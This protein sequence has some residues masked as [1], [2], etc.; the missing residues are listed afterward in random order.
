MNLRF[1]NFFNASQTV[2]IVIGFRSG[3]GEV[4]VTEPLLHMKPVK[5]SVA[6]EEANVFNTTLMYSYYVTSK[7]IIQYRPYAEI[8]CVLF[9]SYV[10][11]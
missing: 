10:Y 3:D 7:G 8:P 11:M 1:Y 6:T 5:T 9:T 4:N 2:F